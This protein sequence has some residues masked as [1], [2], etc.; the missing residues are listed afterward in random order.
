MSF[1]KGGLSTVTGSSTVSSSVTILHLQCG[2]KGGHLV[3]ICAL[4]PL[5]GEVIIGRNSFTIVGSSTYLVVL[6]WLLVKY[7]MWQNLGGSLEVLPHIWTSADN[8]F[9]SA[10]VMF[11]FGGRAFG[12]VFN[13]V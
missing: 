13:R 4:K 9:V 6:C 10:V 5:T 11:W 12:R 8:E 1:A 3:K 7:A 2:C